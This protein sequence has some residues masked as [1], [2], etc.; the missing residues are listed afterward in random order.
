VLHPL[1]LAV[2]LDFHFSSLPEDQAAA[3]LSDA[4][5]QPCFLFCGMLPWLLF[6]D[7]VLR[8]ALKHAGTS[9]AHHGATLVFRPRWSRSLYFLSSLI[10]HLIALLLV[11]IASAIVAEID[12][13]HGAA[14]PVVHAV[15]RA[16]SR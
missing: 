2:E 13:P 12:Q 1:A 4:E 15:Y 3:G 7:T 5:L 14:A 10:H 6:Q 11:M 16:F 9:H 8:S